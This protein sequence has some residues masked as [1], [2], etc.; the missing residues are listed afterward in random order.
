MRWYHRHSDV[1]RN[2]RICAIHLALL[3]WFLSRTPGECADAPAAPDARHGRVVVVQDSAATEAFEPRPDLVRA[4]VAAGISKFTGRTNIAAAWRLLVSTQDVVGIKVYCAPGANSGTRP[5][6]VEA[7]VEGLLTAKVPAKNIIIWDRQRS[8]LRLAGFDEIGERH[9]V[10]VEGALNAGF[11]EEAFY[12]PDRPILGQLVFG[13]LEFGRNGEGIGRKS[14]V[15]KLLSKRI[16][17][18]ITVSPLLNHNSAGVC[19]N[20]FSL[21]SGSVDNFIR[22]ESDTFRLA[23]AV[24]EIYA[25]PQL[26]DRVALNVTDALVCQYHGEQRSLLH[27]SVALNELRFSKDPVALDLLSLR[28]LDRQRQAAKDAPRSQSITNHMELLQNA[29]LLE[30]GTADAEKI[31]IERTASSD[32]GFRKR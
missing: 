29:S 6:V 4:M 32:H 2:A 21:A 13:D 24:P 19:G 11:D 5:A 16:T 17:K 14:Y 23:T 12:H 18:I 3:G 20:L 30:L 31:R 22:F 8:D 25:L 1:S 27:Y 26:S 28:D 9:G 10:L 7:I 15:S